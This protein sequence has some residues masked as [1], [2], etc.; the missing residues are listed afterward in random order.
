M[1]ELSFAE[2][3]VVSGGFEG[4]K[5][6]FKNLFWKGPNFPGGPAAA[7]P[8]IAVAYELGYSFG[9]AINSFNMN[10]SGMSLGVAVYHTF[11]GGSNIPLSG[12]V[13]I[14]EV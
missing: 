4:T 1:R 13:R 5:I 14:E 7:V 8:A 2:V 9:E 10:V 11:N 12:T 6:P 3:S